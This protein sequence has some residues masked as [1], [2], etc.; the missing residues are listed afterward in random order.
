[1]SFKLIIVIKWLSMLA[2]P[3]FV[4]V[5]TSGE[6]AG[7]KACLS[8]WRLDASKEVRRHSGCL[9]VSSARILASTSPLVS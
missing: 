5:H 1:M 3:S 7:K 8:D 9:C 2:H 6:N 4:D